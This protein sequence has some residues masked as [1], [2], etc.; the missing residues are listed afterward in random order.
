M[1][2]RR[3][4]ELA[5]QYLDAGGEK[6]IAAQGLVL[7]GLII[8]MAC[9]IEDK[10]VEQSSLIASLRDSEEMQAEAEVTHTPH[11]PPTLTT[12]APPHQPRTLTARAPCDGHLL[13]GH[14]HRHARPLGLH[15][16][17][18]ARGAHAL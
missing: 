2:L 7:G 10:E 18:V 14:P 16:P 5:E 8:E 1:Q 12:R 17:P 4:R 9:Q 13:G 3:V 15:P 6:L 11:Q